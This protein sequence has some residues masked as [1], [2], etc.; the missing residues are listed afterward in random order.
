MAKPIVPKDPDPV[1]ILY[2]LLF[3]NGKRYFGI[4]VHT[5]RTRFWYGHVNSAKYGSKFPIHCA[6][7][8]YGK[9]NVQINTKVIGKLSYIKLLEISAITA[10]QTID[11]RYGYNRS[12]GGDLSPMLNPDVV[13]RMAEAL[14]GRKLSA[15][16]CEKIGKRS[17]G[18][19]ISQETK[20]KIAAAKKGKKR[21]AECKAKM[22]ATRRL[23]GYRFSKDAIDRSHASR[24]LKA[25]ERGYWS[26]P[27]TYAKGWDTRRARGKTEQERDENGRYRSI[28]LP[29]VD[30]KIP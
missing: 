14:T 24:R 20:D 16:H 2:E 13:A 3:P 29:D 22:A 26:A 17:R 27:E 4:T 6:I 8:K 18:R 30:S 11:R 21:S 9:E 1:T 10:Y 7:R 23:R 5:A 25:A 15:E 19:T 12:P 28:Q